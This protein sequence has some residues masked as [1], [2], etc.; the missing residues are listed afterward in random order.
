MTTARSENNIDMARRPAAVNG[1]HVN[2]DAPPSTLA[3]Q[4]VQNQNRQ[5]AN[6]MPGEVAIFDDLLQEM[7]YND[8][9]AQETN[10]NTNVQLVSV[11]AQMGLQPLGVD[12]PFAA[13]EA[14]IP[15]AA[16]SIA[17]I[18]KT[19]AR[20]PEILLA[21]TSEDGPQVFLNVLTAVLAACGRLKCRDL[22]FSRLLSTAIEVLSHSIHLWQQALV[23]Q[24]VIEECVDGMSSKSR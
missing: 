20:Q 6:L 4:I 8:S 10:L 3:A 22:P 7:L 17:V 5:T 1:N 18:E 19:I 11:M 13:W 14:A 15:R 21:Q 2:G 23:L 12:N 24:E 16:D 9:A